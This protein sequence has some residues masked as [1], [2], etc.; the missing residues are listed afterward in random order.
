MIRYIK[1]HW[2]GEHSLARSFW[3]NGV[4][5][6]MV[7]I[8]LMPYS[9]WAMPTGRLD[10]FALRKLLHFAFIAIVGAWAAVGIWR[11]ANAARRNPARKPWPSLAQGLVLGAG[12]AAIVG[13][14][15]IIRDYVAVIAAIQSP[16]YAEYRIEERGESELVLVGA[17]NDESV[18]EVIRALNHPSPVLRITSRGGLVESAI[19]LARF[20]RD[21]RTPVI[22]EE[23]C[24]SACVL[25]LAA[26]PNVT[27][28]LG[29]QIS[30]HH[31]EPIAEYI[32]TQ[33]RKRHERYVEQVAGYYREFGIPD[34]AID[35][36]ARERVWTPSIGHLIEM[37]IIDMIFDPTSEQLVPAVAYCA[38]H[39][40]E[41]A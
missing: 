17:I 10:L 9:D 19:R 25:V 16:R 21:R 1:A 32:S 37:G 5:P 13:L 24:L 38:S 7:L 3:I 14:P 2:R 39:P 35:R 15:P 12:V 11:S 30:F 6:L 41:C 34:W 33:L 28:V 26:S 23:E 29:S 20:V 27:V 22:A 18:D 40:Q 31:V 36:M 8:A 4:L